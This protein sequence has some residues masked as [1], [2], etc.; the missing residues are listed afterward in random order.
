MYR[1]KLIDNGNQS[2]YIILEDGVEI[3]ETEKASGDILINKLRDAV[4]KLEKEPIFSDIRESIKPINDTEKN[5]INKPTKKTYSLEV[6]TPKNTK[7]RVREDMP[8]ITVNIIETTNNEVLD[9]EINN[10]EQETD[11][12][13]TTEKKIIEYEYVSTYTYSNSGIR[14]GIKVTVS[15]NVG[16]PS[17]DTEFVL[18]NFTKESAKKSVKFTL[19]NFGEFKNNTSYPKTGTLVDVV[20][21]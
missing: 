18:V 17:F 20:K 11:T 14:D 3:F 1:Y 13:T 15:N 5:L 6:I 12:V 4:N 9:N 2:S 16:L 7:I 21:N 8:T 10:V 19:D